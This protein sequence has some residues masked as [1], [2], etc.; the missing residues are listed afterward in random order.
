MIVVIFSQ[1]K[2]NEIMTEKKK[3]E[4]SSLLYK[5]IMLFLIAII[6]FSAYKVGTILYGYYQ[7]N[8]QY[9]QVQQVAGTESTETFTG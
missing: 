5:L 9:E 7:G 2:E 8:S 3:K 4:K 6:A 1:Q